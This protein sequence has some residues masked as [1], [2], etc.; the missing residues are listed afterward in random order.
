M[1][2]THPQAKMRG[3][4]IQLKSAEFYLNVFT[5][6]Q[7]IQ[8]RAGHTQPAECKE[9]LCQAPWQPHTRARTHTLPP[10]IDLVECWDPQGLG[11][12]TGHTSLTAV[13]SCRTGVGG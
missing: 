9:R 12:V 3:N 6:Q 7:I 13:S 11:E 2:E 1:A 8:R 10:G 4:E 5:E